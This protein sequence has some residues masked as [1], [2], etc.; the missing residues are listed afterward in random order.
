MQKLNF[1]YQDPQNLQNLSAFLLHIYMVILFQILHCIEDYVE[2][3]IE[4]DTNTNKVLIIDGMTVANQT[5]SKTLSTCQ[6][7]EIAFM[8]R[9]GNMVSCYTKVR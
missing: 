2:S 5:D 9:I 1:F 7:F 8:S 6:D 3:Y 4:I